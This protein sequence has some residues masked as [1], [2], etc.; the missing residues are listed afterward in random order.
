VVDVQ[1]VTP[2]G[3]STVVAA[4]KYTY[5]PWSS[6][7]VANESSGTVSQFTV[8]A[9]GTLSPKTPASV[10]TGNGPFGVALSADGKS[11]YV[12][13]SNSNTVSQFTVAA[14]GA[15]S[16][17]TPANV[18]TGSGPF[19]VAVSADGK[20]AYV[21]NSSSNTVSQYT[22][23][24]DGTLSPKTPAT[25]A[26][27]ASPDGVALS[28]GPPKSMIVGR[29]INLDG[30]LL[31]GVSLRVSG[32]SDDG[33]AVSQTVTTD[34]NGAYSV[35]VDPGTYMVATTGDPPQQS[36]GK[37]TAI[38]CDGT[39]NAQSQSCALSRLAPG[40]HGIAT[41]DYWPCGDA[42]HAA[43]GKPPTGCPIIFIPGF[44]GSRITC[45]SKELWT[46]LPGFADFADMRLE[47]DGI[48]NVPGPC[49]GRAAPVPGN[50]GLVASA[51]GAD[52]YGST[53]AWLGRIAPGHAFVYTFDW[54]K[55]PEL[56][57][58][59]LHARIAAVLEA[60]G[61]DR[62]VLLAHSM[63]GLVTRAY[64]DDATRASQVVRAVTVGTP[65]WGAPKSHFALLEGDT[66]TPEGDPLDLVVGHSA[67]QTWARTAHGL[68]WLYPSARF[69][70]W[71]TVSSAAPGPLGSAGVDRWVESL[72][73]VPT[74]LDNAQ[75]GHAGIDSF[76]TNGVDYQVMVGVGVPTVDSVKIRDDGVTSWA[77]VVL[78]SGD[79]TVPGYSASEGAIRGGKPPGDNVPIHYVC[80]IEHMKLTGNALVQ[81]RL[82]DFLVKG[83][84]IAGPENNC[85]YAGATIAVFRLDLS[86]RAS[87]VAASGS[88]S[89]AQARDRGLIDVITTGSVSTIVTD[90]RHPV[91]LRLT[92]KGLTMVIQPQSSARHG[93]TSYFGPIGGPVTI[94]DT[95]V[96]ARNGRKLKPG[97]RDHEPP[98]TVA[99]VTRVGK[100]FV[101]RLT[102]HDPSGVIATYVRIGRAQ[103]FRYRHP[104]AVTAQQLRKL[105]F[106]SIDAFGNLESSR[107]AR[108]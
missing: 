91:Q 50:D 18:A 37:W 4:D 80:N 94:T 17:K 74:L 40:A 2:A 26:T 78:G 87:V 59:G 71:L 61:A 34:Q 69:G 63:G 11:A 68:F 44:L 104:F 84:A 46:N 55:S 32:S 47:S 6:A 70:S 89:V 90:A 30:T 13:N 24:A 95:G 29:A 81:A 1:V 25:V 64:L 8:A 96:V 51:G 35:R 48:T 28:A 9:N 19:A 105:R 27:G 62:V 98:R 12:I 65:Y 31:S 22:V 16:P 83:S 14:N 86:A 45:G 49:S 73:G 58:P 21:T 79:G 43:A 102:A 33:G 93:A 60:T 23:A 54:R 82:K 10:A 3:T 20:S 52:V 108:A 107:R 106:A 15:L 99:R 97:R 53:L 56:A 7:Y 42:E 67:L 72:G 5:L 101:I 66:D 92:G 57:I 39:F 38:E 76:K 88:M 36:G 100:R 41:F 77:N 75:R 85:T 103:S